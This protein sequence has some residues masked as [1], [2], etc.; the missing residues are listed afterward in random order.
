[1]NPLTSLSDRH[2][3]GVASD[4]P[5]LTGRQS[6]HNKK[7]DASSS[8]GDRWPVVLAQK[9]DDGIIIQQESQESSLPFYYH[10]DSDGDR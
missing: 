1:M 9:N 10:L 7:V 8:G 4:N 2:P 6:R 3:E 5:I